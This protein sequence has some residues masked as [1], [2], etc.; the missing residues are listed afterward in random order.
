M[1]CPN[2]WEADDDYV[3]SDVNWPCAAPEE[4][5][6]KCPSSSILVQR[7]SILSRG[8]SLHGNRLG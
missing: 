4:K 3:D 8:K 6:Q 7:P 2:P 1:P 5:K